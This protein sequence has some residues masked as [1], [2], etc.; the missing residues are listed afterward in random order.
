MQR[1]FSNFAN[2]WAGVGLL[3]LRLLSGGG[4]LYCG[5]GSA[6]SAATRLAMALSVISAGTGVMLVAGFYTPVAGI[7]AALVEAWIVFSYPRN[8]WATIVLMAL[9]L[10][11]AMIGPGAFSIDA[12]LFGRKQIDPSKFEIESDRARK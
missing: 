2:G 11:L 6:W 8:L 7:L 12:R 9:G 3:L 5:I 10:S 1:L 4:L